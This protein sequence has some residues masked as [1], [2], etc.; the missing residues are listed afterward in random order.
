M[1]QAARESYLVSGKAAFKVLLPC[2]K[3][4]CVVVPGAEWLKSST[5][6]AFH[7]ESIIGECYEREWKRD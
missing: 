7:F 4:E 5:T 2:K 3:G 1:P 6:I